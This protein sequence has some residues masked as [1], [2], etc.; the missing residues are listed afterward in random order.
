MD[1]GSIAATDPDDEIFRALAARPRRELLLLL[2]EGEAPVSELASHFEIT[3]PAVSKH[4]SVLNRT[5]L[6]DVRQEGRRNIYRVSHEPLEEVLEWLVALD[7]FW[8][9]HLD[10]IGDRLDEKSE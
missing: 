4:L 6:V 9:Q 2:A 8:A 5:G 1:I 7:Q 3:R 10:G